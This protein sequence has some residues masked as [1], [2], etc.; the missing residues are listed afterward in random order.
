MSTKKLIVFKCSL[1]YNNSV[2]K[3]SRSKNHFLNL[4][5]LK[6]APLRLW[7]FEKT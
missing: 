2:S 3:L 6:K 5:L 7:E 1:Y 4:E